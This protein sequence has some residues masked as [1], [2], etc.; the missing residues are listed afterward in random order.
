MEEAHRG[1]GVFRALLDAIRA[2]ARAEADV[3]GLRLYVEAANRRAQQT[4]RALG[5][6]PGGYEVYED[7]WIGQTAG[8]DR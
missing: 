6:A 2:E 1:R 8:T 3:I 7:L 4:Y 5:L